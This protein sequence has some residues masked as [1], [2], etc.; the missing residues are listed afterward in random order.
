MKNPDFSGYATK[1]GLKCSDGRTIMPDAFKHQDKMRVPLVWAHDHSGHENV[2]GHAILEAR[3]DGVY[4]YGYFNDTAS[5]KNAKS[6]VE[7]GDITALSIYANNLV[8]RAKQVFHGAI[9]EVSLVLAG[10]NPGARI[11]NVTIAHGDGTVVD[12]LE[13]EAIIRMDIP[14]E[15]THSAD[16]SDSDESVE[17]AEGDDSED[18]ETVEDV[19]ASMS[20]KQK[21][22]V[23]F[24]IGAA[25]A[26]DSESAQH[27]DVGADDTTESTEDNSD[28]ATGSDDAQSDDATESEDTSSEDQSDDSQSDDVSTDATDEDQSLNHQEGTTMTNV[29]EQ[30]ATGAPARDNSHVLTHDQLAG[31]VETAKKNGGHFKDALLAHAEEYG[32]TD[33]NLLFPDA[34]ALTESPQFISRRM[35]WVAAVLGGTKHSPFAKVKTLLADITEPEARA[36]GYIKGNRKKDEVF[37]LLRRTTGPATIYKKQKLDRDDMLDITDIDVVNWL[38]AEMRLMIEEEIARAILVGDGRSALSEDKVKDPEGAVD[39]VGIR[40]ILHD[41]DLYSIKRELAANVSPKDAVKGL[42][43]ARSK[44]RGSGKPTLFISDAYLTDIML[45]EDKFG[46]ALYETE[47][48]LADKLRVKEI[49]TVDL[50]DEYDN[51]FAIMVSLVDYTI[52]SNRGGELTN[53]EDFDIDF[54]QHKYLQET[55]LSGGLTKPFSAIVVRRGVGTLAV[56]TQPSFDGAT[57][58]ITIPT[59]TGVSYF[60]TSTDEELTGDVV[61]TEMTEVEARPDDGYYLESNTTDSWTYTP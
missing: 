57:N 4:T 7:H 32:I 35:E 9:K 10:A 28:G 8:E 6:L 58:T 15:L 50:F 19:Y 31:I 26:A 49:I 36:R 51:L 48:A 54:N 55:R 45:E 47:Q 40:S 42:V 24:M 44:Y 59:V 5:G 61:I 11:D 34:K 46:R 18:E 21:D 14:L 2:L 38:K 12:V 23:H 39:G 56:A 41:D 16:S 25:L 43:R 20:E 37:K 13:D 3:P 33:I 29:F 30:N 1:A 53:F 17:H 22:V 52:G 60:D 27:S